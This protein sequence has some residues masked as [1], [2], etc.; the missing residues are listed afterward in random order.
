MFP[1][2]PYLALN[3]PKNSGKSTVM[4]VM[5]PL[6]FDHYT[7]LIMHL[8]GGYFALHLVAPELFLR[9]RAAEEVCREFGRAHVIKDVLGFL[10][11]LSLVDHLGGQAV[12]Q[13][14]IA[15]ILEDGKILSGSCHCFRK[16]SVP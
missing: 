9:L 5:Q 7:R 14:A 4:R 12:V 2:Y 10:E 11:L 6:T 8:V 3:G 15:V 13:S 1:A 16:Q